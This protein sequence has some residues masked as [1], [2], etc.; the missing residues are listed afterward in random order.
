MTLIVI[1]GI[2][3]GFYYIV[4]KIVNIDAPTLMQ[5]TIDSDKSPLF[6][7]FVS[8]LDPML[9]WLS[10]G[11]M[12]IVYFTY[13]Q[14]AMNIYIQSLL[15]FLLLILGF[16]FPIRLFIRFYSWVKNMGLK[17]DIKWW[18]L[19]FTFSIVYSLILYYLMFFFVLFVS[20]PIIIYIYGMLNTTMQTFMMQIYV[21]HVQAYIPVIGL[22][23]LVYLMDVVVYFR[24]KNMEIENNHGLY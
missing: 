8:I 21:Q 24:N 4:S 12:M 10:F 15:L 18:F 1:R 14:Y 16:I 19:Y 20:G 22:S 6:R 7:A 13:H 9:S 5:R 3:E 2:R 17:K 11:V 23:V